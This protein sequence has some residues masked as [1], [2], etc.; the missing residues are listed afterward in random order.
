MKN[1]LELAHFIE[2]TLLLNGNINS[3]L[4]ALKWSDQPE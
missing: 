3:P 1:S 4:K 2:K